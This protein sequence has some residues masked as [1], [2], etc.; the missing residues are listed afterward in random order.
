MQHPAHKIYIHFVFTSH[1][2]CVCT[3]FVPYRN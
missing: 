1:C 3:A 2:I